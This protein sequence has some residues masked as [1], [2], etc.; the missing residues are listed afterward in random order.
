[1]PTATFTF[2]LS[3]SEERLEYLR[4]VHSLEMAQVLWEIVHNMRKS[5]HY[6]IEFQIEHKK[7]L[8]CDEIVDQIFDNIIDKINEHSIDVNKLIN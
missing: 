4:Y 6:K 3:D 1:M 7:V 2:N 8:T 5:M